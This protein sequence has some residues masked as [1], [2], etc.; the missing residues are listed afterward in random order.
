MPFIIR[1]MMMNL[2]AAT[3]LLAATGAGF[4]ALKPFTVRPTLCRSWNGR[5]TLN[6]RKQQLQRRPSVPLSSRGLRPCP[7]C[8]GEKT[9]PCPVCQGTGNISKTGFNKKN[10]INMQKIVGSKW[11]STDTRQGH[12]HYVA[13]S[14]R[15]NKVKEAE[16]EL[17]NTCGP[18]EKRVHLWMPVSE[19][20]NKKEWRCGWVT[21]EEI[22]SG[23]KDI[24]ICNSCKGAATVEC[25]TCFGEG[26][27]EVGV[28]DDPEA[29]RVREVEREK[30]LFLEFFE[31]SEMPIL[32]EGEDERRVPRL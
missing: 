26:V 32:F 21:L 24:R 2:L 19:L 28:G 9:C 20:Q 18:E 31:G 22:E 30:R 8:E 3:L 7:T 23:M 1:K 15:R 16:V 4:L 10:V 6:M 5:T 25:S 29:V 27:V 13:R 11:T 14:R 12:R 17:V